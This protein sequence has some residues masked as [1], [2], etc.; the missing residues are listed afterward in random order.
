VVVNGADGTAALFDARS[1]A[2]RGVVQLGGVGYT[3]ASVATDGRWAWVA[4]G[5]Q[6]LRIDLVTQVVAAT[7][8]L[9]AAT[10]DGSTGRRT[11]PAWPSAAARCG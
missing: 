3:D 1:G 8:M 6:L 10:D 5:R 2:S 9:A 7:T 4:S 11:R